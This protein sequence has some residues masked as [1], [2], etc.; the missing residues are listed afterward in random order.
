MTILNAD[1]HNKTAQAAPQE[2]GAA[3]IIWLKIH[4]NKNFTPQLQ[5]GHRLNTPGFMIRMKGR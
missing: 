3:F 1:Y 2:C 4:L 5:K